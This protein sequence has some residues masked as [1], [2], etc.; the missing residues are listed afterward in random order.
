[1]KIDILG[2]S[3]FKVSLLRKRA[4]TLDKPVGQATIFMERQTKIRFAKEVDPDE[5]RWADLSPVTL[6]Q[7]KTKSIL[8]EEAILANSIQSEHSGREGRVFTTDEKALWHQEGTKKMPARPFLGIN[9]STDI[10][11][12]EKIFQRHFGL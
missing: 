11:K 6:R 7:K 12:I 4:T 3:Q 8:R 10:P 5:N 1:M 2:N 9:E